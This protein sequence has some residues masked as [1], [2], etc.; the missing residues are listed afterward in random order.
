MADSKTHPVIPGSFEDFVKGAT[1][2]QKDPFIEEWEK[3]EKKNQETLEIRFERERLQWSNT[4][5]EMSAKLKKIGEIQELVTVVYTERQRALEYFHYLIS[6]LS[7]IN[8]SYRKQYAQKYEHYSF[9]SQ[10]RF[11]NENTKNN[12]ILSEMEEIVSHREALDNHA[13]FMEG[14]IKTI[15]NLIYGIKSRIDVEQI[16]RG[17]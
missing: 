11:P 16:S 7:R 3:E 15:D 5:A 2:P 1:S 13:K 4:V 9:Q 17:K 6:L 8:R 14:T 12:Q 10:K